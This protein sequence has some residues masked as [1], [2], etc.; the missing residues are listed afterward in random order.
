MTNEPILVNAALAVLGLLGVGSFITLRD[1]RD[2]V[3]DLHTAVFAPERGVLA[4]Q[5]E[6]EKRLN[7]HS[8]AL[9]ALGTLD[10]E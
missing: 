8:D 6:H 9:R 2:N 7:R 4:I 1:V 3:R 5:K 10:E